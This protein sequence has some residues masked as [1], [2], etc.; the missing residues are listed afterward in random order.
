[1]AE[2]AQDIITLEPGL[3]YRTFSPQIDFERGYTPLDIRSHFERWK[4]NGPRIARPDYA[5]P[6][7]VVMVFQIKNRSMHNSWRLQYVNSSALTVLYRVEPGDSFSTSKTNKLS[8]PIELSSYKKDEFII[9][10]PSGDSA[11]F[12][13]ET[14]VYGDKFTTTLDLI[15]V[16]E[17]DRR[18]AVPGYLT[19]GATLVLLAYAVIWQIWLP[20]WER[21]RK[22]REKG[23]Q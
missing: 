9:N 18:L 13:L 10:I 7:W 5:N 22:D 1:M 19:L 11:Y 12:I 2:V 23:R 4:K 8:T 17:S 3:V 20:Y 14:L 21:V 6:V 15:A 16:V